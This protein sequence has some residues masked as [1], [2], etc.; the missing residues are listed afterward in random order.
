MSGYRGGMT[1]NPNAKI[2]GSKVSRRGRNT[3]LAVGGG[4]IGVLLLVLLGPLLGIDLTG[5]LGG[6]GTSD[7]SV[8]GATED[9]QQC[10]TGA[11]A[12]ENLDCRMAGAALS[13]DTYW[14]SDSAVPGYHSP[15]FRLFAGSTT[16]GC[17]VASSATG[18]FYCPG[19]QSIYL[20]TGFFDELRTRFGASGGPLAQMYVVAHEWGHH[21][22]NITGTMDGL[23]L[24][25]TGPASDSVRLELQADCFAGAWA[26]AA[27]SVPD[28]SGTPFLE[29]VTR[30]EVADAL[31]AAAAIGDDRIQ[32][33]SNGQVNSESWTHG[34]SAQ[35]Q[36]WFE[37]GFTDGSDACT[38]FDGR[39]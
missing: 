31:N 10:R 9:L 4:G 32:Q 35:R 22:Q 21:I 18:P 26:G 25:D 29:P 12:N 33:K 7:S 13:I 23:D 15:Q 14:A 19:D 20:D 38:T 11:D 37:T 5:L 39:P 24:R 8:P 2:N 27:S 17:G 3:G 16:T 6:A 28:E 36:K 30:Q 34:S 1:F